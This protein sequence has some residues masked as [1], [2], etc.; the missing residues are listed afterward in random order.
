MVNLG[1]SWD[2]LLSEEF[3]KDYYLDLR[4]KLAQEYKTYTIYIIIKAAI[5]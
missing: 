5:G 2:L 1:N 3:S 4:K